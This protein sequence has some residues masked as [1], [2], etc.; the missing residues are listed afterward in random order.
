M[1]NISA[2]SLF[3]FTPKLDFL[4]SI[5]IKGFQPRFSL[6]NISG[7]STLD[8]TDEE[9]AY[10]MVCFCDIP[11][12]NVEKHSSTYG[13]YAIGLTKEWGIINKISPILYY[14]KDSP[15]FDA[16]LNVTK[17]LKNYE[18][19]IDKNEMAIEMMEDGSTEKVNTQ[20]KRFDFTTRGSGDI[21]QILKD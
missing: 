6:E 14:Y 17:T 3:H 8:Y 19:G 16:I 9:L 1:G 11:L 4:E 10:P 12:S 15:I 7:S 5:L 21:F 2:N 20:K 18:K 13:K